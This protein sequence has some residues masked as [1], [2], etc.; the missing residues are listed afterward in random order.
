MP[1][2][3]AT[4]TVP[5]I[6]TAH[7]ELVGRPID[8]TDVWHGPPFPVEARIPGPDPEHS[9]CGSFC[10]FSDPD[11]NEWIVQEVTTRLPAGSE[12]DH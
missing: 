9:R 5:D 11:G 1:S 8:A 7:D 12:Q 2:A 10:S 4:L 3:E 6:V